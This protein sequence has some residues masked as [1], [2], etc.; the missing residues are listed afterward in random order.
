MRDL[1]PSIAELIDLSQEAIINS[2]AASNLEHVPFL[3]QSLQSSL[4][5]I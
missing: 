2:L 3:P 4:P 1:N 5:V